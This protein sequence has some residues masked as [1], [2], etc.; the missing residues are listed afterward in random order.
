MSCECNQNRTLGDL[1]TMKDS[2]VTWVTNNKMIAAA[3]AL[4]VVGAVI[5][6]ARPK[7]SAPAYNRQKALSGVGRRKPVTRN[8]KVKSKAR[9]SL[10]GAT[11]S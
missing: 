5:Y 9:V 2:V 3:G 7:K 1:T 10:N 4:A 8:H 6:F 11:L